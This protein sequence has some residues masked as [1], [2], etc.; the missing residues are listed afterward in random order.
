MEC[1]RSR[2][3]TVRFSPIVDGH[4]L[5]TGAVPDAVPVVVD[6][7][8]MDAALLAPDDPGIA[9]DSLGAVEHSQGRRG[10]RHYVRAPLAVA[11]PKLARVEVDVLSPE[12]EYLVPPTAGRH[13][14]AERGHDGHPEPAPP[15][16]PRLCPHLV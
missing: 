1:P 10:Q 8:E 7:W 6:V 14:N 11:N 3:I 15:P 12:A 2:P 9:L 16:R 5:Q 4:A 13:E